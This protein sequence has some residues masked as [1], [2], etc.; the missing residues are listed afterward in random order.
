MRRKTLLVK[1]CPVSKNCPARYYLLMNRV[2]PIWNLLQD[3]AVNSSTGA[4]KLDEWNIKR[5]LH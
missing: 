5:Q 3:Y 4:K 2:A 1:Y